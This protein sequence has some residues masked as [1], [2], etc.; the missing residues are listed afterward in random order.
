MFFVSSLKTLLPFKA[1]L[2]SGWA[3][4]NHLI[5]DSYSISSCSCSVLLWLYPLSASDLD[6]EEESTEKVSRSIGEPESDPS[7][8]TGSLVIKKVLNNLYIYKIGQ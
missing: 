7:K 1:S 4:A 8:S 5:L 2:I 3:S 6:S